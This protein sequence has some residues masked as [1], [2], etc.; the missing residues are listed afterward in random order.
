MSTDILK[1]PKLKQKVTLWVHPEGQVVGSIFVR[2]HSPDHA[3]AEEPLEVLN[4][5]VPFVVL[6]KNSPEELRFYNKNSII[7]IE[8]NT[9]FEDDEDLTV[10][11]CKLNMMDGSII[12]GTIRENLPPEYSRLFDYINQEKARFIRLYFTDNEVSLINK[13]YIVNISTKD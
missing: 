13:S 8:Y 2:E 4:A 3:G 12:E 5:D 6:Q 9:E 7:R 11:A 1:V 10:L